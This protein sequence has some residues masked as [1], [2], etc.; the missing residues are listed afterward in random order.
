MIKKLS[1]ILCACFCL[2]A[3]IEDK[4]VPD[5]FGGQGPAREFLNK[6]EFTVVVSPDD[7][8]G[9]D[10]SEEEVKKLLWEKAVEEGFELV[11]REFVKK[12]FMLE[13]GNDHSLVSGDVNFLRKQGRIDP[14]EAPV[15][16]DYTHEFR[17]TAKLQPDWKMIGKIVQ[18]EEE[19][20]VISRED[21]CIAVTIDFCPQEPPAYFLVAQPTREMGKNLLQ[22]IGCGKLIHS[23]EDSSPVMVDSTYQGKLVQLELLE[24][25]EEVM[26]GDVIIWLQVEI[27]ALPQATEKQKPTATEDVE[28]VV[29]EPEIRA[30]N[31]EPAET[32]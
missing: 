21:R 20:Y 8:K 4:P 31:N 18:L 32:K 1:I 22:V 5:Y 30:T 2:C 26:K 11:G 28:E 16:G 23:L 3:C 10:R 13:G 24:T 14:R 27:T 7:F 9:M 15:T 29:V 19:R 6:Q 12:G 17:M 25:S